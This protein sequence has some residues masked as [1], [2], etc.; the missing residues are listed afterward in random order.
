MHP[1]AWWGAGHPRAG[2]VI[3]QLLLRL[4][5]IPKVGKAPSPM[6]PTPF[7]EPGW[8]PASGPGYA[9]R[10]GSNSPNKPCGSQLP[11]QRGGDR[12]KGLWSGQ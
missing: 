1:G 9:G 6:W 5:S 4:K 8:N 12:G 7:S 11:Q 10:M 2:P 3:L